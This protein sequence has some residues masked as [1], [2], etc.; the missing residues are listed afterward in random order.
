MNFKIITLAENMV[1]A[2]NPV[3]GEHGLSYYIEAGERKLLFD[4]GQ[5]FGIINNAHYLGIDLS[6]I[7]TVVLSH[8]HYDH[9]KGLKELLSHNRTF[10]MIAHP[11]VSEPKWIRRGDNVSNIGISDDRP[12]LENSG[13]RIHF[14]HTPVEIAPGIMT[15]GEI[16]MKTDFETVEPMFYSMQ[17]GR[18]TTDAIPDEISLILDTPNGIV[19]I[20]GCAHRGI[21]NILNHVSALTG[22]K[23]IYAIMGGLHLMSADSVKLKKV[24]EALRDFRIEKMI[25]G[26]CTGFDAMVALANA[27][28]KKVI[29]NTVGYQVRF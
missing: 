9:G 12:T 27:F 24:T 8:G 20:V 26:H 4:C 19:V 14:S 7:E 25:I 22:K 5:G 15:S 3:I 16:P 17:N 13:I 21:I 10:T 1:A 28:G 23:E 29:P 11:A 2:G 18:E 6:K